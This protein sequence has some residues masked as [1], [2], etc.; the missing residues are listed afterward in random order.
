MDT[1]HALDQGDSRTRRGASMR[2]PG[3]TV[4]VTTWTPVLLSG[5]DGLGNRIP[6]PI[7]VDR[8][9]S[10]ARSSASL[11]ARPDA[12][13]SAAARMRRTSDA[14]GASWLDGDTALGAALAVEVLPEWH[15]LRAPML[16]FPVMLNSRDQECTIR[17]TS[18]A[19]FTGS[20]M[21]NSRYQ[22]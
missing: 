9:E 2:S 1:W 21:H 4:S 5:H 18:D 14:V 20:V 11:S 10:D 3:S 8:T 15:E 16:P 19:Q 22:H 13:N 7:Y 6:Y 17:R 12:A